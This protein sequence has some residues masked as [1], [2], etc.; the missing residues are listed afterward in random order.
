MTL[1]VFSGLPGTGKT[2]LAEA[3]GRQL[4]VP[5]FAVAWIIGVLAPLGLVDRANRGPVAYELLTMLAARQLELGQSAILDGMVGRVAVRE[6]WA[7]LAREHSA[8]FAA[9]ECVC[10]DPV[11]HRKRVSSR[12]ER[13]P[14]WPN[15]GWDHVLEMRSR[16][17]PWSGE[18]LTV[19]ALEPFED[20][21]R[22][23]LAYVTQGGA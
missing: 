9:I 3:V 5:V 23:V 2:A 10:T 4:E 22:A 21:L 7:T 6:R 17:E 11:V 14:G 16:Y 13:I 8:T 19:D 18:R 12:H 1:I 20:N 15:P